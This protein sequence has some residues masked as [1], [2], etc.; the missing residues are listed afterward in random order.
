MC[1]PRGPRL[2]AV[3]L[4]ALFAMSAAGAPVNHRLGPIDPTP[5][6]A[7]SVQGSASAETAPPR[8]TGSQVQVLP[9]QSMPPASIEAAPA[10]SPGD[11]L[12][13]PSPQRHKL[14]SRSVHVIPQAFFGCWRGTSISSDSARYLGGCPRG[15]EVPET[16]ELCFRKEGHGFVITFQSAS[17]TLP[18]FQDRTSLVS[19]DGHSHIDLSDTGSYDIPGLF[20][21]PKQ[22]RF[23]GSSQCD[24]SRRERIL[25]C[26]N[27]ARY[28]CDGLPWYETTGRIEMRPVAR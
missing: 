14:S 15:T 27:S 1:V 16:Q 9:Q 5:A 26:E 12:Q 10:A 24:L 25:T 11:E 28:N 13:L 23:S 4:A 2:I 8:T 21:G 3:S 19:S 22:V 17:A 7:Q 20:A 18:N 6:A